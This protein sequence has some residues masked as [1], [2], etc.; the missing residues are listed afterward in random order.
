MENVS[1]H[2]SLLGMKVEDKVTQFKGVAVSVSFDLY[3]CVQVLI[4]PGLDEKGNHRDSRW[5]DVTRIKT[6][7]KKPV[8]DVPRFDFG[9]VAEGKSGAASKPI[10]SCA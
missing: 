3:G 5:K 8:M 1:K 6:V 10:P 2:L 9:P 7:G 4:D